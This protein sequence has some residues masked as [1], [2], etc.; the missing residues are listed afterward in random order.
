MTDLVLFISNPILHPANRFYF[1]FCLTL[2]SL[3]F[4]FNVWRVLFDLIGNKNK[5]LLSLSLSLSHKLFLSLWHKNFLTL[6]LFLFLFL[7]HSL[8]LSLFFSLSFSFSLT[9]SLSLFFSL[10][11]SFSF[12]L[13]HSLSL[14]PFL[15]V[16]IITAPVRAS[17][18]LLSPAK[19]FNFEIWPNRLVDSDTNTKKSDFWQKI[20]LQNEAKFISG[21][22]GL[23]RRG[24]VVPQ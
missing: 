5:S 8:S 4:C 2:F 13:S 1:T 10:S 16:F 12:S 17:L 23:H 24:L 3:F 15:Q 20:I 19:S 11:L 18:F 6:S 21:D 7:S 22:V 14:S 9:L